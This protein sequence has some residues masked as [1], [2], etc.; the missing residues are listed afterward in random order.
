MTLYTKMCQNLRKYGN[1]VNNIYY[2]TIFPKVLSNFCIRD[3]MQGL[4]YHQQVP[5]SSAS[6]LGRAPGA[7]LQV[8]QGPGRT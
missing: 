5:G 4:L 6:S 2:V 3:A 7:E 1:I 8:P